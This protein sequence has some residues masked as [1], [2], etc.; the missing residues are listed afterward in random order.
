MRCTVLFMV[1][2]LG[3]TVF[4]AQN[5]GIG[6]VPHPKAR[7]EIYDTTR[8]ILIPRL[9]STQIQ[10][11][12]TGSLPEGLLIY[13]LT[14]HRFQ[15]WDGSQWRPLY[16][17][18][19]STWC[20]P[21]YQYRKPILIINT[22]TQAWL[23]FQVLLTLNTQALINAG[24][25][26]SDAHDLIFTTPSCARLPYWI[27]SGLN[28]ATTRIWIKYPY[29]A[30]GDTDTVFMYYGFPP[31]FTSNQS[32]PEQ[33]MG[34]LQVMKINLPLQ[35]SAGQWFSYSFLRSF[36]TDTPVVI[37]TPDL[38]YN[39][40]QELVIRLNNITPTSFQIRQQ[41]PSNRDDIHAAELVTV[42]ALPKGAWRTLGSNLLIE[43]GQT[44]TN[45]WFNNGGTWNTVS[46]SAS[47][48]STPIVLSQ[49]Q[50][51]SY[52][53]FMDINIRNVSTTSF[54]CINEAEE[55][56]T[57]PVL[58]VRIGYIAVQPHTG[59]IDG[60]V[61]SEAK[62][63]TACNAD[64]DGS[65]ITWCTI[66]FSA[67]F[68]TAPGVIAKLQTTNGADPAHLRGDQLTTTSVNFTIE[69]DQVADAERTHTTEDIGWW[70]IE[71]PGVYWLYK[72]VSPTTA[73]LN[74]QVST[75]Y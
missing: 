29:L 38:T 21:H 46:F 10:T 74:E 35:N 49:P 64:K 51:F 16:V 6:K 57:P 17:Y 31:E 58:Q 39:G 14:C 48:A 1:F 7:L 18:T 24:K 65:P 66:N 70:A 37:A 22:D 5:V 73:F 68:G 53:G 54:Q 12:L 50:D 45:Q 52:T 60:T 28:T 43:A 36:G 30:A 3:I 44:T 63:F 15:Y 11:H 72:D 2:V 75:C 40:G 62:V 20:L 13:N 25:L 8:G 69:E 55:G 9:S 56:A 41:E 34:M 67:S 33:V 61:P 71:L 19:D 26:R 32:P 27:E 59:T 4:Q 47:F 42:F 23:N